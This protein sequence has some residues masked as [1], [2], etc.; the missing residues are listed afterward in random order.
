[1]DQ[2]T[3]I[4]KFSTLT[5]SDHFNNSGTSHPLVLIASSTIISVTILIHLWIVMSIVISS[6]LHSVSNVLLASLSS[7]EIVTGLTSFWSITKLLNP[8]QE[9]SILDLV[10]FYCSIHS[11]IICY[12][13]N[14]VAIAADRYFKVSRPMQYLRLVTKRTC[15]VVVALMWCLALSCWIFLYAMVQNNDVG[16]KA[17]VQ[18]LMRDSYFHLSVIIMNSTL[19]PSIIITFCFIT[20]LI[21]IV[22]KQQRRVQ[23]DIRMHQRLNQNHQ[24]QNFHDPPFGNNRLQRNPHRKTTIYFIVHMSAF[25]IAWLPAQVIMHISLYHQLDF[26]SFAFLLVGSLILASVQM[27]AGTIFLTFMQNEHRQVL[28][29]AF[30]VMKAKYNQICCK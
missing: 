19:F 4:S 27:F 1:M 12:V 22:R 3:E 8:D 30:R 26:K 6:T 23:Q 5:L 29:R 25:V 17:T 24:G 7:S 9:Y 20:A 16:E 2:T 13:F 28:Q 15:A 14:S 21:H 18:I 11:V 10:L